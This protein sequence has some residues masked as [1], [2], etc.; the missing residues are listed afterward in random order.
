MAAIGIMGGTFNPIHIGHIEIAKAAFSQFALDEIWFMPNRIPG[1]KPD[2]GLVS[3]ENRLEMTGLA[4]ADI[5]YFKVS[6][7]ELRRPGNTY[8]A[9]TLTLLNR[10]YPEDSFYFIMGADSLDYF[11]QWKNP[12]IIVKY[13]VILAAPRNEL[14][15]PEVKA[16]IAELNKLYS[17]EYFHLIRCENIPCSS[18]EIRCKLSEM[19]QNNPKDMICH[20][21]ETAFNL[22]LPLSVYKYIIKHNLYN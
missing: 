6:D 17:G 15:I 21:E 7:Y 12:E 2:C 14:A 11:D 13:A 22:Y 16:R 5:P 20:P 10:D 18:S 4:I 9:E 1:Y 19:Y 3:G 8:T